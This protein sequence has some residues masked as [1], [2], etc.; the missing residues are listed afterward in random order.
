MEPLERQRRAAAVCGIVMQL[1]WLM[2]IF[3]GQVDLPDALAFGISVAMCALAAGLVHLAQ[4]SGRQKAYAI[5]ILKTGLT[6]T[7]LWGLIGLIAGVAMDAPLFETAGVVMGPLAGAVFGCL[8]A[9]SSRA[10]PGGVP[11]L[12]VLGTTAGTL[13]GLAGILEGLL[14]QGSFENWQGVLI[15]FVVLG[16]MGGLTSAVVFAARRISLTT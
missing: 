15:L 1:G 3:S 2:W 10:E 16:A 14:D 5:T 13:L 6:W 8:L 9:L 4:G 12:I 7:L 11:E